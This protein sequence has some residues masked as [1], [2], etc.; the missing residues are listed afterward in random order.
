M[1]SVSPAL[2]PHAENLH[3][4]RQASSASLVTNS[5]LR[6]T[7]AVKKR[8]LLKDYYNLSKDEKPATTTATSP[9]PT[10]SMTNL[11]Q[12]N[13]ED[14]TDA[15][16]ADP[17]HSSANS[18]KQLKSLGPD[19]TDMDS[20]F[21]VP[22]TFVSRCVNEDSLAEMIA[23][24]ND[25]V[26]EI[27]NLDA[28][29]KTLVYG[30]YN[31]FIAAS[32][33]I[34]DMR[35][36]VDDMETQMQL[37]SIKMESISKQSDDIHG[38]LGEKRA[39]IKQLT[40]VHLLLNKLHFVF[41]LPAKL[42]Q[43]LQNAHYKEA[44]LLY[45]ET[46]PLLSHYKSLTLF[47]K[48]SAECS[49]TMDKVTQRLLTNM[50]A[51][52]VAPAEVSECVWMLGTLG[53]GFECGNELA[54][55]YLSVMKSQINK[56]MDFTIAQ[57]NAL[58]RAS[59]A[60]PSEAGMDALVQLAVQ[61]I[62]MWNGQVL[63]PVSDFLIKYH[64]YF[65]SQQYNGAGFFGEAAQRLS[66][67]QKERLERELDHVSEGFIQRY[68]DQIG[69]IIAVPD[70]VWSY[71]AI[72]F[73]HI[74]DTVTKD[75]VPLRGLTLFMNMHERVR[76]Y[77][78]DHVK[79]ISN[80]AF[81]AAKTA[82][83]DELC[84]IETPNTSSKAILEQANTVLKQGILSKAFS[85]LETFVDERLGFVADAQTTSV[86]G[87]LELLTECFEGFWSNLGEEMKILS[88]QAYTPTPSPPPTLLLL[89]MSRSAL[90]L[91]NNLIDSL[92]AAFTTT[93]LKSRNTL[94]DPAT[95]AS[96]AAAAKEKRNKL[97]IVTAGG[98]TVA[99]AT[100][101]VSYSK[102]MGSNTPVKESSELD[103]KNLGVLKRGKGVS[104]AWKG[105]A[106]NLVGKFVS[107]ATSGLCASVRL[108][109]K[110]TQWM[111]VEGDVERAE[112]VW[113]ESV[114]GKVGGIDEQLRMVYDEER[115][116]VVPPTVAVN[117]TPV[118]GQQRNLSA[119]RFGKS[120]SSMFANAGSAAGS[121]GGSPHIGKL[122]K[123]VSVTGGGGGVGGKF[124]AILDGIDR[125]FQDRVDYFG[126]VEMTREGILSAIL[127]NVVKC[128]IEELRLQ[129]IGS[130][131]LHQVQV[132]SAVLKNLLNSG[133][134]GMS[135]DD[136]LLI[137]LA[138]EMVTSGMKRCVDPIMMGMEEVDQ[139]AR[140]AMAN[141]A[142]RD[143]GGSM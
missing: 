47:S 53:R 62:K 126:S 119:G 84:K 129:T 27:K 3:I 77:A 114:L 140:G 106:Q 127:R 74:F 113:R 133:S 4:E 120:G 99:S 1:S 22:E 13:T 90:S 98:G 128:Y 55:A 72:R 41:E 81:S 38:F 104:L 39:K 61:Q 91:S 122:S 25:L 118:A 12:T 54:G 69:K 8:N 93:V 96:N 17:Q 6:S 94:P 110:G 103:V 29:M 34:K 36:K 44:V 102:R 32:D 82:Y 11:N 142:S 97:L 85:L 42:S 50:N 2:T 35:M 51:A 95:L 75:I 45:T 89:I 141:E 63:K 73:I 112:K 15:S 52:V 9:S 117:S 37:F 131:G 33:T 48:I 137:S 66:F 7:S 83:M 18:S 64:D 116:R 70:N 124:D 40:G 21:F 56:H 76:I 138:D 111:R 92:F 78:V 121:A 101:G 68:F 123:R 125:M 132:D 14:F 19:P 20:P 86:D 108:Y 80:N 30:N 139:I 143:E 130:I 26:A 71:D 109:V 31:K 60:S 87:I 10:A 59:T 136:G 16:S 5:S 107:V 57:L 23:Q 134:F 105:I 100:S 58:K 88:G 79:A 49:A 28:S 65:L 115:G 135:S 43:S 24:D 67:E 46:Q